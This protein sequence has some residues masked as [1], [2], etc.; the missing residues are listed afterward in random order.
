V[1]AVARGTAA[2][3]PEDGGLPPGVSLEVLGIL[4]FMDPLREE[5]PAAVDQCH[6]AGVRVIMITGDSPVTARAIA[7]RAGLLP[8]GGE[9]VLT[10]AQLAGLSDFQLQ[11]VL[12]EAR[13]FARVD[14]GQ[15]LR[16]VQALQQRGEVVA[17]TGDGVNDAPALRAADI[18]VA[19][20]Q[21]GT[22]VARE[23]AAL[24]LLDDN[25]AS[26]VHAVRAGRRIFVNLRKALGYLFAVHVPIVG[27]SL[28]PVL[29]GG[30]VLLLPLHVVLLELIIDPAC[31]LV[32]EAEPERDDCMQ[33]P[34]R[35]A[36]ARLF[37]LGDATRALAVGGTS[38]A[39]VVLL[40]WLCRQPGASTEMLRLA[41]LGAIVA[42][43]LLM[44]LWFR[45]LGPDHDHANPAFDALILGIALV[46]L[47]LLGLPAVG[48]V[49]GLPR[50][51][52]PAWLAAPAALA[53]WMGGKLI[54]KRR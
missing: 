50:D 52:P 51:L 29:M 41:S 39:G 45:G 37:S 2:S 18:G 32:F 9:P 33:V 53:A 44:L 19:M 36:R 21:R 20:G 47:A 5:V 43:N 46:W 38:L 12:V 8:D 35:P 26:L 11:Q 28:M 17:M 42:G 4:G 3:A 49:F 23:A 31:S 54:G 24:V 48:G 25:F 22:D 10:G 16:I 1:I 14:P 15:K 40:Q 34:P 7:L 27:V 6:Q 30:P 13:V